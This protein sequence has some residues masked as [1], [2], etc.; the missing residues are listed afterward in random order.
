MTEDQKLKAAQKIYD[1]VLNAFPKLRQLMIDSQKMAHDLG[2]VTTFLG[3]RRHIPE[4]QLPKFEF[5]A[6]PGYVNP[7]IDPMDISTLNTKSEIPDRIVKAL[8]KEFN[9]Y[10]YFGQIVKRTKQLAEE[11]IRV[12]NNT[13]KINDGSRQCVNCVD[14]DTQILTS[15]GWRYYD[16]IDV[17]D[18]IISF[19]PS[20]ATIVKDKILDI[21]HINESSNGILLESNN[22]YGVSTTNHR[23]W[24][25]THSG[26]FVRKTSEEIFNMTDSQKGSYDIPYLNDN[27]ELRYEMLYNVKCSKITLLSCW[28][29]TTNTGAWIAKRRG[30]VFITSNSR[31]QGQLQARPLSI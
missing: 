12:I 31:I 2:Y 27:M 10:K 7:D 13:S 5:K 8:T 19:D 23:W 16:D 11:K 15:T 28:C 25:R 29:V 4:M 6:M 14:L 30:R 1:S 22:V 17:G 26:K 21:H 9:G 18:D 24:L 3:R 20:T